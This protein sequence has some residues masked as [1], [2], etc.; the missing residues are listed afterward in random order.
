[1]EKIRLRITQKDINKGVLAFDAMNTMRIKSCPIAQAV[2][3]KYPG[4]D[5]C[6]GVDTVRIASSLFSLNKNAKNWVNG[7]DR[8]VVGKPF[9]TTLT[10]SGKM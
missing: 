3:R 2:L 4:A 6:V 1:M 5:I 9:S 7:F 8:R 10:Y